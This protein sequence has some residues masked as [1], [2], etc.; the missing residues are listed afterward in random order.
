MGMDVKRRS[1][2]SIPNEMMIHRLSLSFFYV[3]VVNEMCLCTQVAQILPQF[4]SVFLDAAGQQQQL[5]HIH[6]FL[7]PP[8]HFAIFVLF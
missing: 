3:Y 5:L 8:P 2:N 7:R 1:M 6:F 4:K